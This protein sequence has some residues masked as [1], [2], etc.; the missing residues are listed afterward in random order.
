VGLPCSTAL[1]KMYELMSCL[2]GYLCGS[3]PF[4]YIV[5]RRSKGLDIREVDIGNM[6]AGAVIRTV[7]VG[8]GVFFCCRHWPLLSA[9][10]W[11]PWRPRGCHTHRGVPRNRAESNGVDA[12]RHG[13]G[14]P[15]ACAKPGI[16]ADLSCGSGECP[17][18]ASV[19]VCYLPVHSHG[20]LLACTCWICGCP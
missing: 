15:L 3:I 16:A 10:H 18:P 8:W 9:L 2:A 5:T 6:G 1:K 14:A 19:G 12:A 13:T 20:P 4:A 7:G 11:I 17:V